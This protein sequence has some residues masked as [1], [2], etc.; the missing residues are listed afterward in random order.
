MSSA[1]QRTPRR[2]L[3]AILA[4]AVLLTMAPATAQSAHA[5]GTVPAIPPTSDEVLIY[6]HPG[7]LF[8]STRVS[9]KA[10]KPLTRLVGW[11]AS[12]ADGTSETTDR[13]SHGL[14][15][16]SVI[17]LNRT[18]SLRLITSL[19]NDTD[20]PV[21]MNNRL[22]LPRGTR[23]LDH[24]PDPD[25]PAPAAETP[26]PTIDAAA[27]DDQGLKAEFLTAPERR[28]ELRYAAGCSQGPVTWAEFIKTCTPADLERIDLDGTLEAHQALGFNVPMTMPADNPG[29][30]FRAALRPADKTP[31]Q[32]VAWRETDVSAVTTFDRPLRDVD[33]QLLAT[34]RGPFL[35]A[36]RGVGADGSETW[37]VL[38]PVLSYL[39]KADGD[40]TIRNFDIFGQRDGETMLF[41]HSRIQVLTRFTANAVAQLGYVI[42]SVPTD[43]GPYYQF[44]IDD[45][46][47]ETMRRRLLNPDGTPFHRDAEHTAPV[48][49]VRKAIQLNQQVTISTSEHFDPRTDPRVNLRITDTEGRAVDPMGDTVEFTSDYYNPKVPGTYQLLVWWKH[50]KLPIKVREGLLVTVQDPVAEP[51]QSPE[52]ATVDEPTPD[53]PDQDQQPVQA[54]VDAPAD[55]P[56]GDASTPDAD[57]DAAAGDPADTAAGTAP[58][59]AGPAD[60]GPAA[61]AG[62]PGGGGAPADSGP[63]SAGDAAEPALEV[64]AVP[65]TLEPN[66]L[67]P[68]LVE[69]H[70]KE[71]L[72]DMCAGQFADVTPTMQFFNDICWLK[73]SGITTG[74]PDGTYRPVT[75]INR[76]AMIAYI[77]RMAGSPAFTPTKQTFS[78]VAPST[79]YYKEIEWAAHQGITTGWPD[80]SFRPVTPVARDA[81]AVF[82]YRQSGSP[83]VTLPA[84]PSFHDVPADNMYYREIE[85]MASTGIS[86][87][88]P[89]STYRPLADTNRDAMAAFIHRAV[90][91]GVLTVK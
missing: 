13:G 54:A 23:V 33:G 12:T 19:T 6:N 62:Q 48:I 47:A 53:Q 18:T 89:D 27:F 39:F 36:V 77:Y 2:T 31:S 51:E 16:F 81:M 91:K 55:D 17:N 82:L 46:T 67:V 41:E 21:P 87:G 71:F 64:P 26:V 63:P 14:E 78:D 22:L 49:E 38:T 60:A 45:Y 90:I 59:D 86:T 50:N 42:P 37:T 8:D 74:W 56:T 28:G 75:A 32:P 4:T 52:D 58:V 61:G 72:H 11:Q 76:D 88:W 66:T 85:W 10:T 30:S 15:S 24:M 57:D 70:T 65:N 83:A 40:Y 5:Q 34:L 44:F 20:A 84:S 1:H 3:T 80:G 79:M 29:T 35:P 7:Y 73:E 68:F 25:L 43:E 9:D 69:V